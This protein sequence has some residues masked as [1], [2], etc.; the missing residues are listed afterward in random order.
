MSEAERPAVDLSTL[1]QPGVP[2]W[3][4]SLSNEVAAIK[5]LVGS[6]PKI[7]KEVDQL[8]DNTIPKSEHERLMTRT[9]TLWDDRSSW[10]GS[11]RTLKWVAVA[12]GAVQGLV[13]L[14]L[15]LVQA[16]ASL[17]FGGKP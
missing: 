2:F 10:Q 15:T 8:R 14:G 11:I 9:D 3:A 7:E 12:L 1:A 13:I 5:T 6:I 17:H 16:G 4:L